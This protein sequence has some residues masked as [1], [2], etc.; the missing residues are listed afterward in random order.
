MLSFCISRINCC[1][2]GK[3]S[4]SNNCSPNVVTKLFST[5][6]INLLDAIIS[7]SF[8]T[9][10]SHLTTPYLFV[11][12]FGIIKLENK[13]QEKPDLL[14]D[15]KYKEVRE[16]TKVGYRAVDSIPFLDKSVSYGVLMH[17]ERE[18]G[19]GYLGLK[20]EKIHPFAKII[21]IADELDVMNSDIKGV[22]K[23]GPFET[24]EEIKKHSLDK[25]DYSYSKIFFL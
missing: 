6:N 19:S 11:H 3:S 18:D 16:H 25:F 21:A 22:V 10:N 7:L 17:H 1:N 14:L 23:K 24:L 9:C 4:S 5:L 8:A 12:D 20:G 15:N 2:T 13:L